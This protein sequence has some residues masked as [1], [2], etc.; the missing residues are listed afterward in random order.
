MSW[1]LNPSGMEPLYTREILNQAEATLASNEEYMEVQ[2]VEGKTTRIKNVK[3]STEARDP[4]PGSKGRRTIIAYRDERN[5][6]RLEM[7][8]TPEEFFPVYPYTTMFHAANRTEAE[9]RATFK[10]VIEEFE[11]SEEAAAITNL[12]MTHLRGCSVN[13]V[14]AFGLGRIG[15]VRPGPPQTFYEHAAARVVARAVQAVS[16]APAVL[17]AQD[18]LYTDVCKRVLDEFGVDVVEGFGAKGFS[19]LDDDTVVLAHHPSFPLREIIADIARPALICMRPEHAGALALSYRPYLD[20]RADADSERSR[21]M[22]EGYRGVELP[23]EL[24]RAFWGNTW[25]VRKPRVEC[26]NPAL[27]GSETMSNAARYQNG[28]GA[29]RRGSC[30]SSCS[31]M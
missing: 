14:V 18:P 2:N 17:L 16:S 21:K 31:S 8:G 3:G 12:I 28:G 27:E 26:Q 15:F 23:C 10:A 30:K 11:A 7:A 19:L 22:L 25:Y 1:P 4:V 20:V 24:Q 13:K 6:E 5:L 29:G 9:T